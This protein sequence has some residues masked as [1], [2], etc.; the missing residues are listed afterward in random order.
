MLLEYKLGTTNR[1]DELLHRQDHDTGNNPINED[2]TVWPDHYFCEQHTKICVFDMD[3]IHDNLE[4]QCKWAQYKEQKTLKRWA[5]AHN[6]ITL[7][8]THWYHGTTL[9]VMEDNEL[10]RG[11]T[12]LFHDSLTAGHPRISKTLQLLQQ[13]YWW[14]NQKD[15]ITEYIK[16]CATC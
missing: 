3:M 5:A 6:L 1:A 9:V 16:G 10:R 4:H 11:V 12:T 8:G 2:V 13:Y 15:Y 7:D 14:P